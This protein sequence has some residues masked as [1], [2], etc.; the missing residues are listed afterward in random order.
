MHQ[1]VADMMKVERDP[2]AKRMNMGILTGMQPKTFAGHMGWDI[3]TATTKFNEWFGVFPGIKNFQD[4]AKTTILKRGYVRSLLG[5][6]G[7]LE[8]PGLAYRAV[9]KIIQGGNADIM[10][11]K[12]VEMDEYCEANGDLVHM[13]MSVHDAGQW[14]APDTEEG[15]RQSAALDAIMVDVQSAPF[16]LRVPFKLDGKCGHN[17]AEATFGG[18]DEEEEGE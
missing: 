8:K 3:V 1:V 6:R 5:R 17:W 9:S 14:Q 7:R 10:K 11:Y 15:R 4:V 16:N 2:T 13:L 12:M 18:Y